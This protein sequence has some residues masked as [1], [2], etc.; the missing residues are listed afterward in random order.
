LVGTLI[1]FIHDDFF[2]LPNNRRRN[3][4]KMGRCGKENVIQHPNFPFDPTPGGGYARYIELEMQYE[5]PKYSK[6]VELNRNEIYHQR[7]QVERVVDYCFLQDFMQGCLDY[8]ASF[9]LPDEILW[10]E[11]GYWSVKDCKSQFAGMSIDALREIGEIVSRG[12]L[13]Y[14]LANRDSIIIVRGPFGAHPKPIVSNIDIY[15]TNAFLPF[16][17]VADIYRNGIKKLGQARCLKEE[18]IDETIIHSR[19]S[20]EHLLSLKPRAFVMMYVRREAYPVL[21]IVQ[22]PLK[23]KQP[24]ASLDLLMGLSGYGFDEDERKFEL[25]VDHW[26]LEE[27][28]V[29]EFFFTP[30]YNSLLSNSLLS[31]FLYKSDNNS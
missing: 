19:Y 11:T 5:E 14:C 24:L 15:V 26:R 6:Q 22:N 20:S 29:F 31:E 9:S 28:S 16:A 18:L 10:F 8:F 1:D 3:Y 23:A 25:R 17:E 12:A 27:T 2:T 13:A 7:F 21:T 4:L 30:S